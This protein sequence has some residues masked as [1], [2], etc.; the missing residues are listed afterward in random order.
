M[1]IEHHSSTLRLDPINIDDFPSLEV[2]YYYFN[3]DRSRNKFIT[4]QLPTYSLID[5]CSAKFKCL[6]I[7]FCF[8]GFLKDIS[9]LEELNMDFISNVIIYVSKYEL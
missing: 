1:K 6:I 9:V 4:Y 2:I 3:R 7:N 5:N 8:N